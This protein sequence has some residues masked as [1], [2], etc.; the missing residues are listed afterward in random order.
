MCTKLRTCCRDG[1]CCSWCCGCCSRAWDALWAYWDSVSDLVRWQAVAAVVQW[2]TAILMFAITD[3]DARVPYY[4]LYWRRDEGFSLTREGSAAVG[5]Y[6][7]VF[8][9]LSAVNH[10]VC[11]VFHDW[12]ERAI[13]DNNCNPVRWLEYFFSASI[14]HVMIAQLCGVAEVHL[15]FAVAV[16]TATTMTFGWLQE[17]AGP[18]LR[19]ENSAYSMASFWM[20]FVPWA[21]QWAIIGSHLGHAGSPPWWVY[22][23][24]T[25]EG[26][27]DSLFAAVMYASQRGDKSFVSIEMWYIGLSLTAKQALAWVNFGGTRSL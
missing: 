2:L 8:L 1:G 5:Y 16:L 27:L 11:A 17:A 24:I 18:V 3:P 9:L 4:T 15:L 7:A 22:L 14:M 12:Y 6:S 13:V 23:L 20:G 26:A 25:L 19:K 21:A 10:T